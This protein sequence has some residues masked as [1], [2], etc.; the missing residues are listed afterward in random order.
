M[1]NFNRSLFCPLHTSSP[2]SNALCDPAWWTPSTGQVVDL[3]SPSGIGWPSLAG[4]VQTRTSALAV[5]SGQIGKGSPRR[6]LF[7]TGS[8]PPP[9]INISALTSSILKTVRQLHF[10]ASCVAWRSLL[11]HFS[12]RTKLSVSFLSI[13]VMSTRSFI[14]STVSFSHPKGSLI[15]ILLVDVDFAL[16]NDF[17]D[18]ID[19]P[20]QFFIF[21]L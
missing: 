12:C 11:Y 3:E 10:W 9:P 6:R 7:L 2:S 8:L 13:F 20:I 16:N 1:R 19:V 15:L 14:W 21:M 5:H 17:M 18:V 4:G